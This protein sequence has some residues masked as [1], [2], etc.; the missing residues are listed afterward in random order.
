MPDEQ[1]RFVLAVA[2]QGVL[3]AVAERRVGHLLGQGI[4]LED[5]IAVGLRVF[6]PELGAEK[7]AGQAVATG[8]G[9]AVRQ[10]HVGTAQQAVADRG[11]K[12]FRHGRGLDEMLVDTPV[13]VLLAQRV[14][15]ARVPAG[16]HQAE[17]PGVDEQR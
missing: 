1:H 13:R 16:V 8:Q 12:A 5:D 17:P 11:G 14:D 4:G 15:Q 2:Q 3:L 10:A 6:L 7:R 9:Q